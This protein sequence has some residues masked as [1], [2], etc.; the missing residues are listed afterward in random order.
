MN[1]ISC[2]LMCLCFFFSD[3]IPFDRP[4]MPRFQ[5][6]L[7]C[8]STEQQ[9][10]NKPATPRKQN[11]Q[12]LPISKP[13]CRGISTSNTL[14]K[15]SKHCVPTNAADRQTHEVDSTWTTWLARNTSYGC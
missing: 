11:G 10:T 8:T 4:P 5:M 2:A 9:P 1:H 12:N 3:S 13:S 6:H 7:N 15:L 14:S